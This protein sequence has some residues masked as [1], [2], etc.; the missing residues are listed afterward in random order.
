MAPPCLGPHPCR[1]EGPWVSARFMQTVMVA[2]IWGLGRAHAEDAYILDQNGW[3]TSNA[4]PIPNGTIHWSSACKDG[5]VDKASGSTWPSRV[6]A[7][8]DAEDNCAAT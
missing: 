6:V 3:K 7:T 1:A 5:F 2:V 4:N 8:P